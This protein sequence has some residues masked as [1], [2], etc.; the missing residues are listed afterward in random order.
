[1]TTN[2]TFRAGRVQGGL[3]HDSRRPCPKLLW[4]ALFAIE[5][6]MKASR[7][8]LFLGLFAIGGYVSYSRGNKVK[9]QIADWSFANEQYGRSTDCGNLTREQC[10]VYWKETVEPNLRRAEQQWTILDADVT[11]EMAHRSV[12]SSCRV[13]YDN[14]RSAMSQYYPIEDK[15]VAAMEN[16]ENGEI[17]RIGASEAEAMARVRATS[18]IHGVECKN[19]F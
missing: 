14:L 2:N 4:Y 17:D 6:A 10:R 19:Q 12:S 7:V 13:S 18:K 8:I 15:V 16:G 11:E 9:N 3:T 1:M 5:C